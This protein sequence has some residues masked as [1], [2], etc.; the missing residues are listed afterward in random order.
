MSVA[1]KIG[2][3]LAPVRIRELFLYPMRISHVLLTLSVLLGLSSAA[4]D[5]AVDDVPSDLVDLAGVYICTGN[6]FDGTTYEGVVE[7]VRR[8]DTLCVF[9]SARLR[10]AVAW[11]Q[12]RF[13]APWIDTSLD[14]PQDIVQWREAPP[15][16]EGSYRAQPRPVVGPYADRE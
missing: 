13:V 8:N 3:H 7:I 6:N 4:L 16:P 5:A 15:I 12:R 10:V 14:S 9:G 11:Q 2:S 1:N